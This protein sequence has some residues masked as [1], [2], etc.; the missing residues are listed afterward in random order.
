MPAD[1]VQ[2]LQNTL[3]MIGSTALG[4]VLT[5]T[6]L[7]LGMSVIFTVP[8]GE[9]FGGAGIWLGCIICG[10]VLGAC[11][12]FW[13]GL[14]WIAYNQG[15]TWGLMVWLGMLFGLVAGASLSLVL[16]DRA[17]APIFWIGSTLLTIASGTVAGAAG[18]IWGKP[19]R[20]RRR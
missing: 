13:A 4:T 9:N 18:M 17:Y 12:G 20:R 11:V 1:I 8:K 19:K 5:G 14:R 7:Y 2:F 3:L 16:F 6:T 10:G 15:T